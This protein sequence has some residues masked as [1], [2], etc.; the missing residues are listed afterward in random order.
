MGSSSTPERTLVS[1]T[2]AMRAIMVSAFVVSFYAPI[3]T[4][5]YY[6]NRHR[7]AIR[8]RN[9]AEMTLTASTSF[10]FSVARFITALYV[11]S[12]SC[13]VHLLLFVIPLQ[14]SLL[15]YFL[16][17]LRL[18]LTFKLTELMV[19]HASRTNDHKHTIAWLQMF[20]R[21]GKLLRM[22]MQLVWN[23]PFVVLL[24][25]HNYSD[26]SGSSC[27]GSLLHPVVTLIGCEFVLVVVATLALSLQ[28]SKAVDNFGL[29]QSFQASSRVSFFL[30]LLYVPILV[31]FYDTDVIYAYHVDVFMDVLISHTFVWIHIVLPVRAAF[32][33]ADDDGNAG[34]LQG[35]VGVLNAFLHTPEGFDAFSAFAKTEFAFECVAAWRNLVDYRLDAPNHLSAYD[36]YEQHIAPTAPLSLHHAVKDSILKRYSTAFEANSRYSVAPQEMVQD[37]SYFDVLLD[38]VMDKIVVDTL[39]RFQRHALGVIW[40]D[41]VAKCNT[42]LALDKML[43]HEALGG[44]GAGG[45]APVRKPTLPTIKGNFVHETSGRLIMIESRRETGSRMSSFPRDN[46]ST[47]D[48][49][50]HSRRGSNIIH[51]AR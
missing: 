49:E 19:A 27:P 36:I 3:A 35:T 8:Y 41:F 6:C 51:A 21:R 44:G 29:R 20:L 11:D 33:N 32:Q 13:S 39:P 46:S 43:S 24:E 31:F 40:T 22:A 30:F 50:S 42:Q 1:P 23:V 16:A 17:E 38:A 5:M 28:L 7:P 37:I 47:A 18:V 25:M 14:M 4:L 9:P 34:Y 48:E 15:F 26:L 45:D 2:G 12:F 10:F